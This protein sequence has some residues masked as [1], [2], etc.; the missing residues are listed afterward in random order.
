[1]DNFGFVLKHQ[2]P[3]IDPAEL[4]LDTL[5]KLL[6]EDDLQMSEL[7]SGASVREASRRP[8]RE[9]TARLGLLGG[10]AARESPARLE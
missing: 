2:K 3:K 8:A 9:A 10:G 1:L 7:L 6:D 5:L 4:Q